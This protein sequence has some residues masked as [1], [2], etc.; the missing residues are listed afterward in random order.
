MIS[1]RDY[2]DRLIRTCSNTGVLNSPDV[3]IR[4]DPSTTLLDLT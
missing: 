4:P 3:L 1:F 2:A